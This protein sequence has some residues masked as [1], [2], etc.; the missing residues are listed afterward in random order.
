MYGPFIHVIS[1]IS[2][3]QATLSASSPQS[4]F[5]TAWWNHILKLGLQKGWGAYGPSMFTHMTSEIQASWANAT[6]HVLPPCFFEG[7]FAGSAKFSDEAIA[8]WDRFFGPESQDKVMKE[9]NYID[10]REKPHSTFGYHWHN[11]WDKPWLPDSL[12][13]ASEKLYCILAHLGPAVL[14]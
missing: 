8:Y 5:I 9:R 11:R 13:D 4:P 7:V 14:S 3:T 1:C 12:A 6:F 2:A 10:P